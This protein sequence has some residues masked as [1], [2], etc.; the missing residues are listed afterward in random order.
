MTE[1]YLC[2]I[3]S[4]FLSGKNGHMCLKQMHFK[5]LSKESYIFND[6]VIL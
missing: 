2:T 4:A 6:A 1:V 3:I 5:D